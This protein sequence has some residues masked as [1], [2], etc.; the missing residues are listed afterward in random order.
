MAL[1]GPRCEIYRCPALGSY[2]GLDGELWRGKRL[3]CKSASAGQSKSSLLLPSFSLVASCRE[4]TARC[5]LT[6]RIPRNRSKIRSSLTLPWPTRDTRMRFS[7]EYDPADQP[8]CTSRQLLIGL[9]HVVPCISGAIDNKDSLFSDMQHRTTSALP[10]RE[11]LQ[12]MWPRDWA[13]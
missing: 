1:A 7:R 9:L 11:S 12:L 5:R 10:L 3:A 4:H 2:H 8:W 6:P 13:R